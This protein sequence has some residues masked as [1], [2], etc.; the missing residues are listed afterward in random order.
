MLANPW[1]CSKVKHRT[2][3]IDNTCF[4]AESIASEHAVSVEA[5]V[6]C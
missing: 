2:K 4:L 6:R 5:L 1:H 3:Q